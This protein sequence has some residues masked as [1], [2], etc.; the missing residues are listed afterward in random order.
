MFRGCFVLISTIPLVCGCASSENPKLEE[1]KEILQRIEGEL[2]ALGHGIPRETE[3]KLKN[4]ETM[5]QDQ[6]QWP[7]D[8]KTAEKMRQELEKI[9]QSIPPLAMEQILPQLYRLNWGVEAL[10]NLRTHANAEPNQLEEVQEIITD[11][12]ER[13]PRGHFDEIRKELEKRLQELEPRVRDFQIKGLLD[14]AQLALEGKEDPSAVFTSLEQF[15]EKEEVAAILPKLRIKLF[16]SHIKSLEKSLTNTLKFADDRVRQVF[17]ATIQESILR[18][19]VD[20]EL[21]IVDL[22]PGDPVPVDVLKKAKNLLAQADKELLALAVKQQ[23]VNAQKLRRY[24]AWALQQI[25]QFD[26]PEEG[27]YYDVSLEWFR[28]ELKSFKDATEDKEWT[29]FQIFP[30]L[31]E[32]LQEKLGVDLSEMKGAMLTAEKRREIYNKAWGLTKWTN[33]ID[34]EL[35]Y[36]ATRDGMVKFLLPIQLQLLDPPVAQLYQEAFLKGWKKLEDRKEDQLFVAKQAAVVK[37][38]TPEDMVLSAP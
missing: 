38:K 18:L 28:S 24:Q 27:W 17:L 12:L 36:R 31:K 13:H 5:L 7:Q 9:V 10:W 6:K 1:L 14:R 4:M 22:N 23:D 15:R 30:S 8:S 3:Q 34:Q 19:I 33:N 29:A 20:L 26:H 21:G 2:A 25:R 11:L 37:K 32:V 16:E 35:A